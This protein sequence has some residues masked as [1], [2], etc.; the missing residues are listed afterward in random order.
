MYVNKLRIIACTDS[1]SDL[2]FMQTSV[3]KRI[4]PHAKLT[5]LKDV[6]QIITFSG[7]QI[8]FMGIFET[9]IRF[10]SRKSGIFAKIYIVL[11]NPNAPFFFIG[12]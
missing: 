4:F 6:P 9:E 5:Q 3:F 12:K 11:D 2:T 7:S 8:E 1:G 10:D